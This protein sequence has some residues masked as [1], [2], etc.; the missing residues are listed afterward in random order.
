MLRRICRSKIHAAKVTE[1]RID[2]EG[3]IAVDEALMEAAALLENEMVIV[4]NMENGE[5][6]ETYVIRAKKGSGT[7]GLNGAAARL[8]KKG[9]RV[10][11]LSMA[12]ADD[13]EAETVK[14]KFVKVDSKNRV[15]AVKEGSVHA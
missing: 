7:I 11:I 12:L 6:F 2:Y 9:D 5:R 14:P 8:G 3:S 1:A 13:K 10:I 15:V 4:A